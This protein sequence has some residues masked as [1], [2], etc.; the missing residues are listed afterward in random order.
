MGH[1]G[2]QALAAIDKLLGNQPEK[3]GH[4]FSTAVACLAAF[5]DEVVARHR[6]DDVSSADR[7]RLSRLNGIISIIVGGQ[8][9]IGSVPWS[10]VEMV[11]HDL[12]D[13]IHEM[14]AG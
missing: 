14:R 10:H 8:Y 1:P 13:L 4:D 9:P 3:N 2:E 5:R 6:R 12:A 11:R 7:E